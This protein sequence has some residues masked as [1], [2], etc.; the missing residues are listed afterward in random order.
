MGYIENITAELSSYRV[1]QYK[2]SDFDK[3]WADN[4]TL[5]ANAPLNPAVIKRKYPLPGI[6]VFDICY[7]GID[8]TKVKGFL[9]LPEKHDGKLPC[10]ICYHGAGW[11]KG[12]PTHH[13]EW[14]MMGMAVIAIDIRSQG[15]DT[16]DAHQY[17]SGL[18]KEVVT[19]GLLDKNDHYF[20]YI[21]TDC[22]RAVDFACTQECI[23]ENRIILNGGSQGGALSLAIGALSDKPIVILPDI[24]SN[25]D[26]RSRIINRNGMFSAVAEYLDRHPYSTDQVFTTLSYF[27]NINLADRIKCPVFA[28]VG[29]LDTVCPAKYF[30]AAMQHI[31]T[32]KE[33]KVY[34]FTG[35]SVIDA[36]NLSKIEYVMK[37]LS[38]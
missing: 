24:P 30:F 29:C 31:K 9:L 34:P 10:V 38:Q 25:C 15:G 26:I 13:L 7:D 12:E 22:L 23:D 20:K 33:C 37:L 8:G 3:F 18:I 36:H 1:E 11:C 16:G 21:Y 17:N 14:I 35:H 19:Q 27:D 28:S 2:E 4:L 5:S 6:E 32:E